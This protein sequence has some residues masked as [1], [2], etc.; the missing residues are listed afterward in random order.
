MKWF[1]A[2]EFNYTVTARGVHVRVFGA[3]FGDFREIPFGKFAVVDVYR[4][5]HNMDNKSLSG[6]IWKRMGE[7]VGEYAG[8]MKGRRGEGTS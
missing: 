5:M 1:C 7:Y 3:V 8:N 6:Q 4:S 2:T